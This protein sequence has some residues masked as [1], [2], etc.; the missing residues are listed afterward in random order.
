MRFH[1]I[2]N[3][4]ELCKIN[5]NNVK[6]YSRCL[7]CEKI[8]KINNSACKMFDFVIKYTYINMPDRQ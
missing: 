1:H 4:N 8:N 2:L 3:L 7:I 5:T 6:F